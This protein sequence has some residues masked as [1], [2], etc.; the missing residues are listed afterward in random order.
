M[1]RF[2]TNLIGVSFDSHIR[3]GDDTSVFRHLEELPDEAAILEAIERLLA[4]CW[5]GRKIAGVSVVE[6]S[7]PEESTESG[8][9]NHVR[10]EVTASYVVI[11]RRGFA[12]PMIIPGKLEDARCAGTALYK[13][14][15]APGVEFNN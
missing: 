11:R 2:Y 3:G 7:G 14:C 8:R 4:T 1:K 12:D 9:I 10:A 5:R 15:N 6:V 13:I